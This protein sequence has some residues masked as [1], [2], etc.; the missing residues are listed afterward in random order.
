[1]RR[2][3]PE[4]IEARRL[5]VQRTA[6]LK[7][8]VLRCWQEGLSTADIADRLGVGPEA[9]RKW[10]KAAGVWRSEQAPL[11]SGGPK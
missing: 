8:K 5:R 9:I 2:P 11:N 10:L 3:E 7:S 6:E 4:L 1:M